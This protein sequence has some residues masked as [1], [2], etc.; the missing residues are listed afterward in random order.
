MGWV[1]W[2]GAVGTVEGYSGYSGGVRCVQ[3]RGTVEGSSGYSGGI[4]SVLWRSTV[5][6]TGDWGGYSGR[7]H[8]MHIKTRKMC[9]RRIH[10]CD[11]I[12]IAFSS[13]G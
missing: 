13:E 12:A 4:R 11:F 5:G 1:R 2:K 9:N 3:W 10:V 6:Y 7:A 8:T